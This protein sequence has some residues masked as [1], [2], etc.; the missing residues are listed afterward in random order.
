MRSRTQVSLVLL[1]GMAGLTAACG[2]EAPR[3]SRFQQHERPEI[4][5][6]VLVIGVDG[7]EWRV[8]LPLL[9]EGRMPQLEKLVNRGLA[10]QLTPLEPTL[11]PRLWATIATGKLPEDHGIEDFFKPATGEDAPRFAYRS[12][13]R[14]VKA[15]WNILSEWGLS[16]T[17]LGWW[18]TFPAEEVDGIMVANWSHDVAKLEA[19]RAAAAGETSGLVHPIELEDQV[20]TLL[21]RVEAEL[22]QHV[23]SIFGLGP[24]SMRGAW[25]QRWTQCDWAFRADAGA[26]AMLETFSNSG[27]PS[28][29]TAVY[30]CGTD[31]V[32]HR[33]WAAHDPRAFGLDPEIPEV[34]VFGGVVEDYYVETDRMLGRILDAFSPETTVLLVSDHGMS[35]IA[36]EEG[37]RLSE[38]QLAQYTGHHKRGEPGIFV[39]AGPAIA[40]PAERVPAA[41]LDPES[42]PVFGSV[43][44]FCPTLLALV[45]IPFGED[46]AGRPMEKVLDAGSLQRRP[47]HSIPT[48]DDEAWLRG[49]GGHED[50]EAS[51]ERIEQLENLGYLGDDE[52]QDE[53]E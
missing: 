26:V 2:V 33:F 29:V 46:M 51:A 40:A 53:H 3:Q 27:A 1:V 10:G 39:A 16:S 22:P 8:A 6:P 28:D 13:D 32:G 38:R 44:D 21:E 9:R 50:V 45:G 35:P 42:L 4:D 43:T 41:Q 14:R 48:H 23:Q 19:E 17:T 36:L 11:S 12:L 30:L 49:R 37:A 7:F 20:T 24:E 25:L 34:L 5:A 18:T 15:F 47:L 52:D 31:I